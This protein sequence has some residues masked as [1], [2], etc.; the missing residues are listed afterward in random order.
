MSSVADRL[1]EI[2]RLF[3]DSGPVGELLAFIRSESSR[4]LC[5][6]KPGHGG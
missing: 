3:R 6:P 1:A 2:E 4:A 5:R